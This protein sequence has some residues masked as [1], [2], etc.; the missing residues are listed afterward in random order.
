[1][2]TRQVEKRSPSRGPSPSSAILPQ[3]SVVSPDDVVFAMFPG[4]LPLE[5][6]GP[7]TVWQCCN[8]AQG[9]FSVAL[10]PTC[11]GCQVRRCSRCVYAA[12]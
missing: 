11:P 3:T 2:G 8:C 4:P 9:W 6:A 10:Y 5:T 1:M 12:C 7:P